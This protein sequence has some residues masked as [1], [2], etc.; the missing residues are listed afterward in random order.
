VEGPRRGAEAAARVDP[1]GGRGL[2][3]HRGERRSGLARLGLGLCGEGILRS[4]GR[5]AEAGEEGAAAVGDVY[6]DSPGPTGRSRCGGPGLAGLSCVPG[7]RA[8]YLDPPVSPSDAFACA[9]FKCFFINNEN[10]SSSRAFC[11]FQIK[12][13]SNPISL[14]ST[15]RDTASVVLRRHG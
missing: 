4:A 6:V 15:Q 3:G 12:K 7:L 2:L 13:N 8:V 1:A 5:A 14:S 10:S 11:P 9:F